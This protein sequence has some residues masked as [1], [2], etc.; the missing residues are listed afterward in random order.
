M[1]M[2]P[3]RL[4]GILGLPLGHSLSPA[5]HNW[6]F[7][8]T[9]FPG[10]YFSWEKRSD[11]LPDFFQSVR[12]LPV[13]GLSITIPH[14]QSVIPFLDELTPRAQAVGAVNTMFRRNN[15]LVGD[16]T[17]VA[18]FLAPLRAL[19]RFSRAVVLGA[20]GACRAVLAGLAEL[21]VNDIH[22]AARTPDK[23]APL[24]QDFACRL[25][26]WEERRNVLPH[27]AP[28]LL[29]N[30]T[31]LG[32]QG[33]YED[34]S[35]LSEDAFALPPKGSAVYDLVYSPQNT[36]FLQHAA[37]HGLTVLDGLGFF[38]AQ[39][40]E[41]FRLWTGLALPDDPVRELLKRT[42]AAKR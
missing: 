6:G 18:G 36:L 2:T 39:G 29:I 28:I 19:P 12:S 17:D 38:L 20:G 8:R 15:K 21:G 34:E 37:A 35:P 11:Q 23:A 14:K 32:M 13:E 10:A 25:V 33:R 27:T 24:V 16:N 9:G 42:L 31:P 40:I 7:A 5:L 26:P 1:I 3:E 41:Q 4:Y 22:V 30:T